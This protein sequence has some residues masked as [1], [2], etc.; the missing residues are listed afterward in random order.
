MTWL[1]IAFGEN[2]V[3]LARVAHAV[4]RQSHL[5]TG[6]IRE[7]V[8]GSQSVSCMETDAVLETQRMA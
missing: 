5:A 7:K 6:W 4:C 1:S 2:P 8:K 3:I